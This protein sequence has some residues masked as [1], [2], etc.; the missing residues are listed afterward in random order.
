HGA[1]NLAH[2]DA[3]RARRADPR[4]IRADDAASL[5]HTMAAAASRPE[6]LFTV[7]RIAAKRLG[8]LV[9]A[10]RSQIHHRLPY[11]V[12]GQEHSGW[13]HL[14]AG[15]AGLDELKQAFLGAARPK[16]TSQIGPPRPSRVHAVAVGAVAAERRHPLLQRLRGWLERILWRLGRSRCGLGLRR[17][18]DAGGKNA[19]DRALDE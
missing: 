16:H 12:L 19:R 6:D 11:V 9:G 14:T 10:E 5:V 2:E 13:R 15:N 1:A 7:G 4:Q 8:G 17:E 3:A 18:R